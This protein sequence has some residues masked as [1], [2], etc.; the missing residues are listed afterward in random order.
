MGKGKGGMKKRIVPI[1]AVIVAMINP[2]AAR[3]ES[4]AFASEVLVITREELSEYNIHTVYDILRLVPGATQWSEGPAGSRSGFSLDARGYASVALLLN[5]EP[6]T[7]PYSMEQL[8]RFIPLSRL[9]QVEIYYHAS[10]C[11]TGSLS[12]G[13]AVNIVL[14]TG[15]RVAPGAELDFTYGRGNRRARRIWFA[16]PRTRIDAVIAY[17]EYLQDASDSYLPDRY[18]SLGKYDSRSILMA[19]SLYPEAGREVRIRLHRFEDTYV[20]TMDMMPVWDTGEE[21]WTSRFASACSPFPG[22]T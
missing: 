14:E 10:P 8:T 19:L 4:P 13:A 17:D 7:D 16:T 2:A 3:A 1:V 12:S 18:L 15:G 5:G 20:G 22:C 21:P 9:R 11:L 6:I